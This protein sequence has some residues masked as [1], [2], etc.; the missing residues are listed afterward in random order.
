[1]ARWRKNLLH[2][3]ARCHATF[4]TVKYEYFLLFFPSR[5]RGVSRVKLFLNGLLAVKVLFCRYSA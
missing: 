1:M 2:V 4:T 5:L 3:I